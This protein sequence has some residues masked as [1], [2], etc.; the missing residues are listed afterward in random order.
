MGRTRFVWCRRLHV[1]GGTF[2]L[3]IEN[4]WNAKFENMSGEA[5]LRTPSFASFGHPVR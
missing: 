2:I 3:T 5:E 4:V 1:D